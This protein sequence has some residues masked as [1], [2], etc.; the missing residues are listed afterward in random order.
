MLTL[1]SEEDKI[2]LSKPF[3]FKNERAKEVYKKLRNTFPEVAELL[4]KFDKEYTIVD[5]N[6]DRGNV[7]RMAFRIEE[8]ENT[9]RPRAVLTVLVPN[10]G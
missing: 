9:K 5:I 7:S 3:L 2:Y 4:F 10:D 1:S 6:F 8:K